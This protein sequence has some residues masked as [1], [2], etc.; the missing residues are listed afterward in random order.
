MEYQNT[1]FTPTTPPT[2]TRAAKT[3]FTSC[4]N[5]NPPWN[6]NLFL[7]VRKIFK[8]FAILLLMNKSLYR[9]YI[10]PFIIL[11]VISG[12]IGFIVGL[13]IIWIILA[14]IGTLPFS[15]T[16]GYFLL[17]GRRLYHR[18][19]RKIV[20][21]IGFLI[22]YTIEA[23]IFDAQILGIIY[24]LGIFSIFIIIVWPYLKNLKDWIRGL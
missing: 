17:T 3:I 7:T 11:S 8:E 23:K 16:I 4:P 20:L 9:L 1:I 21:I 10:I 6:L 12:I 22:T 5:D 15:L 13:S 14:I 2:I 24:F 18:E 19:L